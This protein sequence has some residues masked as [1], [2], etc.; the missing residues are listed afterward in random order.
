MFDINMY[1]NSDLTARLNQM[2]CDMYH[3]IQAA[4]PSQFHLLLAA[5]A[6]EGRLQRLYTQ[7]VDGIDTQLAPLKTRIPLPKEEPW[8]KT[9]QLHG[10]LK[11]VRCQRNPNKHLSR[12]DPALFASGSLPC[13]TECEEQERKRLI[14]GKRSRSK[15]P[16]LRPRVWLYY[17]DDY[18]D[19]DTISIVKEADFKASPEVVIVVGTGLKIPSAKMLARD[20]CAATRQGGGF[21]AWINLKAPP[22]DLDCFNLVVEGNCETV[23]MH[24]SSWWLK[25]CPT[26]LSDSQIQNLQERCRLF[27]A[28]SPRA[29]LNR[30]LAELDTDSL[31]KILQQHENKSKILNVK[32]NGKAVFASAEQS[33]INS[34][35]GSK[36][37]LNWTTVNKPSP[38]LRAAP[39]KSPDV[40]PKLSDCWRIDMSKRLSEVVVEAVVRETE[41]TRTEK[42]RVSSTVVTKI[43]K[44][45]YQANPEKSLWR[46]KPGE[47]LDDEII[48]AYLELLQISVVSRS[49]RIAH[50]FTMKM[51]FDRPYRWFTE[52]LETGTYTIYLPVNQD[53]Y[54]WSFAVITSKNKEDALRWTYYDSIGAKAPVALLNWI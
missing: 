6:E 43:L 47:Y 14:E 35:N 3:R 41:K 38:V 21:A 2:M 40:L 53:K 16:V 31:S 20:M 1:N 36:V 8:P 33:Q 18:P 9:I 44:L 26:V 10:D 25:E 29:A 23:A 32:E 54:H 17:N 13:C 30:A 22:R 28:R 34:L 27:I 7:N 24:V 51:R 4:S 37:K 15:I 39:P 52:L 50:S 12:F 42:V 48:N 45:G 5:L 49:H 11:T 19:A 46:L